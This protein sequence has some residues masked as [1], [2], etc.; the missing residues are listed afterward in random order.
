MPPASSQEAIKAAAQAI[1]DERK[2]HFRT[3]WI[4]TYFDES[5]E[6]VPAAVSHY[7]ESGLSHSFTERQKQEKILTH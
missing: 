1:V 7:D 4:R 2:A 5:S 6:Q 3:I